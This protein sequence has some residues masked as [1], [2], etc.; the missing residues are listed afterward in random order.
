M[1]QIA[2]CKWAAPDSVAVD[3]SSEF[4]R[5]LDGGALSWC[6]K[7]RSQSLVQQ[8]P[9]GYRVGITTV[10]CK[11]QPKPPREGDIVSERPHSF[12]VTGVGGCSAV[13]YTSPPQGEQVG[14]P[15][16]Q[17]IRRS[18]RRSGELVSIMGLYRMTLTSWLVLPDLR[19]FY[20]KLSFI[21]KL[22]F[23]VSGSLLNHLPFLPNISP[24]TPKLLLYFQPESKLKAFRYLPVC[25]LQLVMTACVGVPQRQ[26]VHL[27]DRFWG[28]YNA[29]VVLGLIYLA[30]RRRLHEKYNLVPVGNAQQNK[31]TAAALGASNGALDQANNYPGHGFFGRNMLPHPD[32]NQVCIARTCAVY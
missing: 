18:K 13:G 19:P 3:H 9:H 6:Q 17:V 26:V 4:A 32:K 2:M 5:E 7:C 27:F 1:L 29:P 30:L 14:I 11:Y 25:F 31:E 20:A 16:Q 12:R 28:W 15:F 21:H 22:M 24:C 8:N 10:P 23:L